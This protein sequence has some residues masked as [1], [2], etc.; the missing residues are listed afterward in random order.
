MQQTTGKIDTGPTY[1]EWLQSSATET[2]CKSKFGHWKVKQKL[3]DRLGSKV[4]KLNES[5][6][7]R[8]L[9]LHSLESIQEE[10]WINQIN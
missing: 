5:K 1:K 8:W 10:R 3:R 6:S 4:N 7:E 2:K 9:D